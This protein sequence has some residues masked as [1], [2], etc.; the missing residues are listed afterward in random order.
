M[1]AKEQ[2]FPVLLFILLY[3]MVLT[4]ESVGKIVNCDHSNERY[5]ANSG[6]VYY[7]VERGSNWEVLSFGTFYHDYA[8]QGGSNFRVFR[9]KT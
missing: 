1:K 3:N 7:A 2:Y 8:S 5:G 4:Y 6:A 9:L